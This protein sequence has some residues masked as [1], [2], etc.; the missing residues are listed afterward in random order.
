MYV[1]V[2]L[3]NNYLRTDLLATILEVLRN[4]V[5][6]VAKT[7]HLTLEDTTLGGYDIPPGTRVLVHTW[8]AHHDPN[9]W[10]DPYV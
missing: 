8:A 7:P 2:T 4:C 1:L 6:A 5:L 10:E 9:V 3:L